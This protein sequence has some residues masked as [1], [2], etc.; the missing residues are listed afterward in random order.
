MMKKFIMMYKL[1][2]FGLFLSGI[3][4]KNFKFW[5]NVLI[6]RYKFYKLCF[7][8]KLIKMKI[9]INLNK[10]LKMIFLLKDGL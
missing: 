9:V 3:C 7:K 5:K 6:G 8:I 10:V 4:K 1:R 2:L